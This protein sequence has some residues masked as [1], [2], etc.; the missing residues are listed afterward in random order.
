MGWLPPWPDL[1]NG[2]FELLGGLLLWANVARLRRDRM[3]RGV[4]WRVTAFFMA[5]GLWNL[6]YYPSLAQWASFTGGLFICS[7]NVVWLWYA[8][9]FRNN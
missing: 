9:R 3:V 5:W 1:A 8:F 2:A 6:F 7:A 4:D